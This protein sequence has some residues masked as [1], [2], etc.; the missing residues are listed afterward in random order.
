MFESE[1]AMP[2]NEE[3]TMKKAANYS[4]DFIKRYYKAITTGIS[5]YG[6]FNLLFYCRINNVPFPL[7]IANLSIMF[8]IITAVT[9]LICSLGF[10]SL[11]G[12]GLYWVPLS[13]NMSSKNHMISFMILSGWFLII[14]AALPF[15]NF[16]G[17]ISGYTWLYIFIGC[18]IASVVLTS[19]LVSKK[20]IT[21][22][23]FFIASITA[24][25]IF[26]TFW[27][28]IIVSLIS[29]TR[30][31]RDTP[32]LFM[33]ILFILMIFCICIFAYRINKKTFHFLLILWPLSIIV[34][35]M[36]YTTK[37]LNISRLG[38]GCKAAYIIN[39]AGIP[40]IPSFMFK[41]IHTGETKDLSLLMDQGDTVYVKLIDSAQYPDVYGIRKSCI[42]FELLSK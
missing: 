28:Y 3:I 32:T 20:K 41:D 26:S 33:S 34:F 31:F 1:T 37:A 19:I 18:L 7:S 38:G 25:N 12:I 24:F 4:I 16:Y 10:G 8:C 22:Q 11:I 13:K 40:D 27:M 14:M 17:K 23:I 29:T 21:E 35:S 6:F 2:E 42:G 9:F 5:V 39:K 36:D 30:Q 15:L